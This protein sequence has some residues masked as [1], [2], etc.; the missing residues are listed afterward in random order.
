[1]VNTED[2]EEPSDAKY[3]PDGGYIPRILFIGKSLKSL[4]TVIMGRFVT[5][6]NTYLN[7]WGIFSKMLIFIYNPSIIAVINFMN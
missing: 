4:K 6:Y 1:M 2:D 3:A 7:F 5:Q